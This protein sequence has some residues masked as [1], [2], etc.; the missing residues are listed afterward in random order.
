VIQNCVLEAIVRL[1]FVVK[2]FVVQLGVSMIQV[3]TS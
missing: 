3:D 1:F 2:S